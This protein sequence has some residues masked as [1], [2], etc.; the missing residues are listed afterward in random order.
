[1][2]TLYPESGA[3]GA[4]LVLSVSLAGLIAPA[5][6]QSQPNTR[7]QA[8]VDVQ[9]YATQSTNPPAGTTKDKD[10]ILTATP[11][12]KVY[13]K[14]ANTQIDG[15]W[16]W[17]AINYVRNSQPDRI[18]PSGALNLHSLAGRS[19]FGLDASVAAQQV[20]STSLGRQ[21]DTPT[22]LDSY[23]DTN[24]RLSPFFDKE[25]DSLTRASLRLDRSLLHSSQVD[26]NLVA[27]P[28]SHVRNDAIKLDRQPT[29][30]GYGL[31]WHQQETKVSGQQDP[32]LDETLGRA[33]A[34]YA[35]TPEVSMGLSLGRGRDRIG[36][37][38]LNETTHGVQ[39]QWRP[40]ERSL[41]KGEVEDR[42]FGRS[43]KAEASH[44]TPWIALGLNAERDSSTYA[45]TIGNLN[46]GGGTL[47][48]LYDALLTTRITD[49][50]A[51]RQAVDDMMAR[52]NLS[53]QVSTSGDVYDV[54]AQLRTSTSG[55]MALMGRRDIVTFAAGLTR[56]APL[57]SDTSAATALTSTPRTK[58]YF[59][60][61]QLNHQLTLRSSV[62]TGLRWTRASSTPADSAA[63][64]ANGTMLS[65]DFT[66][67][68]SFNT[69]LSPETTATMGVKRQLTHNPSTTSNDESA[70]FVG[71]GHR[72]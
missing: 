19:G 39:G 14:G 33:T 35:P 61:A 17:S 48:G 55:R 8:Q 46:R 51:R 5:W 7:F 2:A 59:F 63:A 62:A 56:T 43:W 53:S 11:S 9:A 27:R 69:T 12:F 16:Q 47:S 50:V 15:Q 70:M 72:F 44:R 32:S 1:M 26:T 64:T 23:T 71:L 37:Q 29:P 38:S 6:A 24:Y 13:A 45:Q 3:R 28:D 22:T 67:R 34:R 21:S 4:R 68:A 66:W 31:E 18:L 30:L 41:L 40:T 52:R 57:M 42:Y 49:P 10:L 60:D 36:A 25:L 20:K 65:R 54:A 58:E